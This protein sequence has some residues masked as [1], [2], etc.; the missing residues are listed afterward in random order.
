MANPYIALEGASCVLP[1]GTALFSHLCERFDQRHTGLIGRNGVGKTVLARILA[2]QVPLSSG[3]CLRSGSVHYLA[4]Q[5]AGPA[6]ST[7]ADLA[8]VQHVLDALQRIEAG[9]AASADFEAVGDH[10]DMRQRLRHTLAQHGLGHLDAATPTSTLSGGEAMR[11][12]LAGAM[13]SSADFLILDEPSN[14]LDRPHRRALLEHLRDWPRGLL[15]IS[16]DRQL[17][18][19]MERIVELSPQGLS[20]FN[21]NYAFHVQCRSQERLAALQQLDQRKLELQREERA[22]REQRER[23]ERRQARGDR[24]G[25]EG[26]QARLLLGRRKE[27]SENTTGKLHRQHAVAREQLAGRIG[28]VARQLEEDAPVSL[29]SVPVAQAAQRRVA[30]LDAVRLPFVTAATRDISLVLRGQ[31][32]VGVVGPNGCGKSTLLKVLAGQLKPCSGSCKLNSETVY[33]DQKLTSLHPQRSVLEQMKTANPGASESDLR[34]RLAQLGLDA[35]KIAV[36]GGSLSGG[37]R[38]KATL[39]LTLYAEPPPRLLLLDEPSN[40][41]DLPS[42]QALEEVLR[43]YQGALVVVSHDDAFMDKLGLTD[44]LLATGQGWRLDPW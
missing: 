9:S 29:H 30:E 31:Q 38:L 20:S 11:V 15:V 2:G 41:L 40:H 33:L 4:Q 8:G 32:R 7:A 27:R 3:H 17:L 21:G 18:E 35:R 13:L 1:D 34:M 10:W 24:H 16:H 5:I 28:V 39:A 6:A 23:Q 26:N 22:M 43:S 25:K 37:E 42:M 14:H 19:T 44:R 36:P 12:A